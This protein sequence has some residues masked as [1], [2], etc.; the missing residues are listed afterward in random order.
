MF[1]QV[2]GGAN[3]MTPEKY[4][5]A[6]I[7]D[8]TGIPCPKNN[9]RIN[10]RTNEM[11]E[12]A[13]PNL[14]PDGFDYSENFDGSQIVNGNTIYV[15]LKCVVGSGGSQ[16]RSLREVYWFIKGQLNVLKNTSDKLYFANVLDGDEAHSVMDKYQHLLSNPEYD[17]VKSHVY[18]GDLRDYLLW[19][20]KL[21]DETQ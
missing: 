2:D 18:V 8:L 17:N 3:S 14:N 19:V 7:V 16:T 12:V 10:L 9:M 15:N 4:Q 11:K 6:T 1:G 5:R 20:N 21:R 13:F